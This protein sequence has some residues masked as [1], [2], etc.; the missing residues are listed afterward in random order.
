MRVG[1]LQLGRG[2]FDEAL[3]A[4]HRALAEDELSE[5]AYRVEALV[6]FRAGDR[7]AARRGLQIALR[8]LEDA[9]LSVDE[10]LVRLA[11]KLGM[12]ASSR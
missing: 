7:S 10:D 9:G 5:A 11:R 6:Y 1:S 4:V 2:A 3:R 12:D 8:R